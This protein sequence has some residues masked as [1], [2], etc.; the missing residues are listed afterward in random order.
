MKQKHVG[1]RF[2]FHTSLDL[3]ILLFF[4]KIFKPLYKDKQNT[5]EEEYKLNSEEMTG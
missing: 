1:A 4:P 2:N 5:T 3:F